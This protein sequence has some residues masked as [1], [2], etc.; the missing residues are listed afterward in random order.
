[1]RVLVTGS[2]GRLGE[3]ADTTKTTAGVG[4][5]STR[6]QVQSGTTVGNIGSDGNLVV[7]RNGNTTRDIFDAEGSFHADV[8]CTTFYE[9]DDVELLRSLEEKLREWQGP[10]RHAEGRAVGR[11]RLQDPGLVQGDGDSEGHTML[12]QTKLL[13]LLSGAIRQGD[14]RQKAGTA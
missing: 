9:H 2:S 10:N 7:V 6:A 14:V 5:V 1:M 12:N 8:E 3:A 4:V 13:W 11:Q